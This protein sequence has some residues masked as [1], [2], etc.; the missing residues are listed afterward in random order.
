M[1]PT[2]A[3]PLPTAFQTDELHLQPHLLVPPL[4]PQLM[5]ERSD[6]QVGQEQQEDDR[7]RPTMMMTMTSVTAISAI[8]P[9]RKNAVIAHATP[10]VPK[11]LV[12]PPTAGTLAAPASRQGASA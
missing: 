12:S 3:E 9:T 6:A 7:I 1:K 10:L 5:L 2:V 11:T 4:S 8:V